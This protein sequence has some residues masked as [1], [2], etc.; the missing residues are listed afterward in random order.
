MEILYDKEVYSIIGAAMNVHNELGSGFFE[1]V[2]QEAL[3]KEFIL[4][5]LPSRREVPIQ[6]YYKNQLLSKFYIADFLCYNKI[7]IEIKA[8][9]KLNSEHQAQILNYLKATKLE[10]GVLINFGQSRLEYKRIIREHSRHSRIEKED[11]ID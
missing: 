11:D 8:V 9:T 2:Y 5:N 10:L 4:Q 7:I 6:I 1:A 3:E